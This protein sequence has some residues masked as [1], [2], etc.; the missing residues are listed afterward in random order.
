MWLDETHKYIEEMSGMNFMAIIDG[1]LH[2]PELSETILDGIT[3]K[4]ILE[5]ARLEEIK[6]VEERI[7]IDFLLESVEN[8]R[9]S[10]AFVCG[11][12]SVICPINSF[13][14]KDK[15]VYKVKD[16]TGRLSMYLR[17]KLISIQAGR[18]E[19]PKGW[20]HPVPEINF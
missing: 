8:G 10:E 5:I 9:C 19:S 11:T 12:A 17:E 13:L 15:R 4:S 2:T 1:E 7:S 14:D 6:V 3:R 20:I 18:I 16:G